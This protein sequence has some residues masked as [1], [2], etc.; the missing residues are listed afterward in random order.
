MISYFYLLI[1][2]VSFHKSKLKSVHPPAVLRWYFR[3]AVRHVGH[4]QEFKLVARR[5]YR[6]PARWIRRSSS[7]PGGRTRLVVVTPGR[8]RATRRGEFTLR[9]AHDVQMLM[10]VDAPVKR[11]ENN[12]VHGFFFLLFA[13]NY[14]FQAGRVVVIT[15]QELLG[16]N[17]EFDK[18]WKN[19]QTKKLPI[20]LFIG[21]RIRKSF[22][23][24][25]STL[26]LLQKVKRY[27]KVAIVDY[28]V[29]SYS[30]TSFVQV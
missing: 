19:K 8:G 30:C 21:A 4:L 14:Y 23:L 9:S 5:S 24:Y 11:R 18:R 25:A 6:C 27:L 15:Y 13:V 2:I 17:Q 28:Y 12:A 29:L 22:L 7:Q 26:L 1:F 10:E 20:Y 16:D 3:A